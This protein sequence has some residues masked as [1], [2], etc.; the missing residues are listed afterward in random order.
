MVYGRVLIDGQPTNGIQTFAR[1]VQHDWYYTCR[2]TIWETITH[3][4][5]HGC[6]H[7]LDRFGPGW[8]GIYWFD[9][10]DPQFPCPERTICPGDTIRLHAFYRDMTDTLYVVY[11][12]SPYLL[13]PDMN[14]ATAN[15]D[16][17]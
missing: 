16:S 8:Y 12:G 2:Y 15:R 14:I 11:D 6:E 7:L 5:A 17:D 1:H 9:C 4:A 3:D 10:D 13:A